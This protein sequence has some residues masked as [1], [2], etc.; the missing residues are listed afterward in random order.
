MIISHAR[1]SK[2][3]LA[4]HNYN[5]DSIGP[6]IIIMLYTIMYIHNDQAPYENISK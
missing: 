1:E 6:A 2:T 3:G 5:I 4:G